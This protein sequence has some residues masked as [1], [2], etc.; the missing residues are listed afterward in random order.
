MLISTAFSN[1]SF[2]DVKILPCNS[3]LPFIAD[4]TSPEGNKPKEDFYHLPKFRSGKSSDYK[5]WRK[6]RKEEVKFL[7]SELPTS[8]NASE[9][10]WGNS[11]N[12]KN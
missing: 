9:L 5:T 11:F 7:M 3:P 2:S 6:E 8:V 4:F 10:G 12:M 1:S